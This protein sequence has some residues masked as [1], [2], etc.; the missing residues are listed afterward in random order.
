MGYR[1]EQPSLKGQIPGIPLQWLINCPVLRPPA[2]SPSRTGEFKDVGHVEAYFAL[3]DFTQSDVC[4]AE[5]AN[6]WH[7][8][9]AA[10]A[11]TGV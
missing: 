3:D 1:S 4:C 10:A 5:I 11:A 9:P 6:V 8:W 2:V 7:E